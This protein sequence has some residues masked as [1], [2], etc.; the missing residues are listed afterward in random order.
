V[1]VKIGDFGFT[2]RLSG[3]KASMQVKRITHP[4]WVA[5]E[6]SGCRNSCRAALQE[7]KLAGCTVGCMD[8]TC[9]RACALCTNSCAEVAPCRWRVAWQ[10][11]LLNHCLP[12]CALLLLLPVC[13]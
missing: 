13:S 6:V 12:V 3:N 5:P 8:P 4:R 1:Q 10:Q 9:S 2:K 7:E 11:L